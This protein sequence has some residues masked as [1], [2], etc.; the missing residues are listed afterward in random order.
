M[1]HAA[2][3][4]DL[5]EALRGAELDNLSGTRGAVLEPSGETSVLTERW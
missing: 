5:S 4:A 1:R 3:K 2:S